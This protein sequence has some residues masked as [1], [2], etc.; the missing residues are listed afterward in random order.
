MHIGDKV[1]LLH[2]SEEGIITGF[3]P[4]NVIEVEIEMGFVIPVLKNEV[5]VVSK[6]EE[7][8][9]QRK[10]ADKPDKTTLAQSKPE[11]LAE[12]GIFFSFILIN[13]QETALHLVNNTDYSLLYSVSEIS[14][15]NVNG[16]SEGI[17]EPKG[18]AKIKNFSLQN[19][20]RWPSFL[21]QALFHRQG[22]FAPREAFIKTLKFKASTFYKRKGKSPVI[23]KEG[24][25]IQ[26]DE[27]TK[28]LRVD[29]EKLKESFYKPK[30]ENANPSR[31]KVET[32]DLHIESLIPDHSKLLNAEIIEIQ[33]NAFRQAIDHAI[34]SGQ[35]EITFIHGVG[36]GALK[37]AIQKELSEMKNIRYFKDAMKEKFGYGATL[38]RIK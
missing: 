11:I 24:F 7:L 28:P 6:E 33:L 2:G 13:E 19:F 20:E 21:L 16:L 29:P 34:A 30:A 17:I 38:V 8:H 23:G 35:D 32:V 27:E 25:I 36:K 9:F 10:P 37:E 14:D 31:Q 4:G 1:R 5:V 26:I 3:L 12:K 18:F 22:Y 15:P